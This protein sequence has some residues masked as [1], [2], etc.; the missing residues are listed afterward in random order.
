MFELDELRRRNR[1]YLDKVV[2]FVILYLYII[3]LVASRYVSASSGVYGLRFDT[4]Y[5]CMLG[6][7]VCKLELRYQFVTRFRAYIYWC[8]LLY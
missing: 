6:G 3:V 1:A 5:V 7:E 8:L 4:Q 2:T